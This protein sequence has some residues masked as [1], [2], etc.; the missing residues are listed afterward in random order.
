MQVPLQRCTALLCLMVLC[1][2]TREESAATPA[3]PAAFP[4]ASGPR[5][6]DTKIVAPRLDGA[7]VRVTTRVLPELRAQGSDQPGD[8]KACRLQF[9]IDTVGTPVDITVVDCQEEYAE[10]VV[11]AGQEWRFEPHNGTAFPSRVRIVRE[12]RFNLQ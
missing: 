10:Q 2:C 4:D 6:K 11:L 1:A 3:T 12:I 5:S 7:D 8:P 9:I